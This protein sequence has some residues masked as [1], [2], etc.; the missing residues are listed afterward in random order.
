[1]YWKLYQRQACQSENKKQNN[2]WKKQLNKQ[3]TKK[4]SFYS[5]WAYIRPTIDI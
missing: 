4:P 3:W 2:G 1:M 5:E